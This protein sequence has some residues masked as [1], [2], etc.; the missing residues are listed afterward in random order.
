MPC[1]ASAGHHAFFMGMLSGEI[2][3]GGVLFEH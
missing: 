3:L 1:K 2:V